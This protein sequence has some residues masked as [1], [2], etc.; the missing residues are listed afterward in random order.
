MFADNSV[1][2]IYASH[3]LE[4]FSK[5]EAVDVLK[6]WNRVLV[7]GG[8][9]RLAVPDFAALVKAYNDGYVM[10]ALL[11]PLYGRMEVNPGEVLYHRHTYDLEY[12]HSLLADCH[13]IDVHRYDWRETEHSDMDDWS[14]SY[15]PHMDKDHG[16]L[17]SLNVECNKFR[18]KY[19]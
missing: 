16:L 17:I 9:L 1:D 13:F 5:L 12:L 15:L 4:Y 8:L 3:I 19:D 18:R 6:E 7:Q 11:G 14:Q 10:P 2:V